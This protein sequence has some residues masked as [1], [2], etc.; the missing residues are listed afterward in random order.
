M[1]ILI[2]E[3]EIKIKYFKYRINKTIFRVFKLNIFFKII[4]IILNLSNL[5]NLFGLFNLAAF[6][7]VLNNYKIIFI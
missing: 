2:L 7:Y 6:R 4:C 1:L 5:I 3:N